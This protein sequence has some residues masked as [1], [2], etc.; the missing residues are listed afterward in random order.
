[1]SDKKNMTKRIRNKD[2]YEIPIW[3]RPTITIS[4]ASAYS[5]IGTGKL[6]ELTD[7]EDCPFVLWVGTR[8]VI[9][10]NAFENY[11]ENQYSI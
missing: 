7:V 4:E 8:R 2:K 3:N 1:M 9:K 10:R 11:L 6:Y 5:G